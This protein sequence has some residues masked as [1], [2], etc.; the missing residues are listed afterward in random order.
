MCAA[1]RSDRLHAA[2]FLDV[3]M[4]PR[5]TLLAAV[6]LA[7]IQFATWGHPITT[8]SRNMDYY[9]S[10]ELMEPGD[11]D[12]HYTENLIR[13]P[14]IGVCYRKPLIPRALVDSRRG[15]FGLR[16]DSVVYLCCQST[17]KYLPAHDDIFA[18]IASRVPS[19]QFLFLSYNW[20]AE[21]T[22]R[23][24]LEREFLSVNLN[25]WEHCVFLP[26]TSVIDYWGI[27][28]TS[29]VFLD[30]AGWSG[31][32]TSMEA[33]ACGLPVVT[34]P[35]DFMRGR[36]GYAILTQLGVPETIA[37]DKD[38]YI[39]IA[40]RLGTDPDWRSEIV[41]RMAEGE[42]RLYSDMRSVAAVEQVISQAVQDR[43]A[44]A[45]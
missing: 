14:G 45:S 16:K 30:S 35:G 9:L 25:A 11:G 12:E 43:L 36:H 39:D 37:R 15:R 38:H 27:N 24:R 29:N 2:I 42:Q 19:A 34:L 41:S 44:S 20:G 18:R 8:G 23:R 1:I 31:F 17:F 21:L 26:R 7:P 10:S 33:I 40:V 6:R 3:G 28:L 32:N 13:L 5:M 22:F 4:L